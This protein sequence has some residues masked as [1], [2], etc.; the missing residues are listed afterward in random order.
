MYIPVYTH[1]VYQIG[2]LHA[3][4]LTMHSPKTNSKEISHGIKLT[5]KRSYTICVICLYMYIPVY[6]HHVYQIGD[7]HVHVHVFK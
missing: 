6:T 5:A 2:D 3:S 7:L 4:H 1:H